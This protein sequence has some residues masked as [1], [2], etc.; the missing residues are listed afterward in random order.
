MYD[1][2]VSLQMC[3]IYLSE[4]KCLERYSEPFSEKQTCNLIRY[5]HPTNKT[6]AYLLEE[7][8]S[9]AD[10]RLKSKDY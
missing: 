8:I 3:K 9:H 5:N 2:M 6:R 4:K 10:G 1:R 7:R